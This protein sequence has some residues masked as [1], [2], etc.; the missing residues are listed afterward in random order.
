M[1]DNTIKIGGVQFNKA[2]VKSS[3]VIVKDG[4]VDLSIYGISL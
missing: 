1:P 2:D 4:K 3:E